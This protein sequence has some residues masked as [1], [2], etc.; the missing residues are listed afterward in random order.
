MDPL[1][2]NPRA[3]HGKGKVVAEDARRRL[4]EGGRET[5][6]VSTPGPEGASRLVERLANDGAETIYVVGG[7][8][9]L[10][11][12]ADGAVRSGR[13][14]LL[15]LLPGGTGNS[16]LRDFGMVSLPDAIAGIEGAKPRE[17]D[18]IEV[19]NGTGQ[20]RFSLN[21]THCSFA[22]DV[23]AFADRRLKFL[24]STGYS[25]AVLAKLLSLRA[26][27]TRIET[28]SG[29]GGR[30]VDCTLVAICNTRFTG[31]AMRIA[32]AADPFDGL[33]DVVLVRKIGRAR[34]LRLFPKIFDG[35]HIGRPEVETFRARE[36]TIVPAKPS[37]L[38]VDGEV[39]G[40]TPVRA[41]VRP[42]ALRVLLPPPNPAATSELA[43][44]PR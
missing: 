12:A 8:G 10:S 40:R 14:P 35:S 13:R 4:A 43:A 36:V 21:V 16:F 33:L 32:P 15:V 22:A 27:A 20:S 17:L 28:E 7:D 26:P 41:S 11:Q 2:F 6:L 24:G 42:G 30:T 18:A 38:L 34:L 29:T 31:G 37:A 9:T 25:V 39:A 5:V 19:R 3:Q 1:V 44:A 23:G